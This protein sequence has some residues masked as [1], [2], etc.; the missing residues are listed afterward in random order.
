MCPGGQAWAHRCPLL[1]RRG[2]ATPGAALPR[3]PPHQA[4]PSSPPAA[5]ARVPGRH[6]ES[7]VWAAHDCSPL[8]GNRAA[9]HYQALRGR[10]KGR[11][12]G[13]CPHNG[14]TWPPT[15]RERQGAGRGV[16]G[17][18]ARARAGAPTP[19]GAQRS[20]YSPRQRPGCER[21]ERHCPARRV[22]PAW[23]GATPVPR[24]PSGGSPRLWGLFPPL[25]LAPGESQS[26]NLADL[27]HPAPSEHLPRGARA[28]P[29]GGAR[30][31]AFPARGSST[32]I[33]R[34]HMTLASQVLGHVEIKAS[35]PL[36]PGA[37][38]ARARTD[39]EVA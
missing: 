19:T 18:A 33:S 38:W 29:A 11:C 32:S 6:K 35:P 15:L 31:P 8:C 4:P 37:P 5:G 27:L 24:T 3:P 17:G 22:R 36:R 14:P 20:G 2:G 30:T 10:I 13:R 39:G 9:S 26:R 25:A 21:A 28:S 7:F 1:G 16:G 23:P 12:R 34:A